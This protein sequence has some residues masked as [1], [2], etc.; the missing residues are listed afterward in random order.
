MIIFTT[1]ETPFRDENEVVMYGS[2]DTIP[3]RKD[4]T[5]ILHTDKFGTKDVL[6][7]API[8]QSRLVIVTLKAPSLSKEAHELCVVDDKLK[9]K[10]KDDTFLLVKAL[11]N[12]SDRKRVQS[13]FRE[14]P[15]DLILWFL[16]ENIQDINFWRR[17]TK[18]KRV[19][20]DSY[21]KSSIIFGIKP[22]RSK[23]AWPKRKKKEVER[24][25]I[26]RSTDQYHDLLMENSICVANQVRTYDEVP[27][28][29]KRGKVAQ[30][31]WL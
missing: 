9:G 20:P 23:V 2:I 28:G 21:L 26:F 6:S 29:M 16:K 5:Y 11:V 3:N 8:V 12:W 10:N 27:K 18:V 13:V 14:Q 7:W 25:T 4:T 24:P 15:T 19:L 30:T 31:T 22:S 17:I 1:D